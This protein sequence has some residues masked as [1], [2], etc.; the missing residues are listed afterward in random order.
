MSR[1]LVRRL[2]QAIPTLW[3]VSMVMFGIIH[4]APGG[5]MAMY[6]MSPNVDQA[7][8][9]RIEER[10]GLNDP[11]PVQYV[12]W[13]KG[14][15]VGDWGLSYKFGR[16]VT[17][18]LGDRI[19]PSI[20]LVSASLIIALVFSV[21]LGVFSALYRNRFVQYIANAGAMLGVSVPT[22]WL[23]LV[24]LLY[25]SVRI[26]IIPSGGMMTIGLEGFSLWDRLYH[27]LPPAAVLATMHL[28]GW[29]RYVR[30]SMLEVMDQ[31]YI[32]TARS[33]GLAERVVIYRHALKNALL[34][35]VTLV[36]LQGGRLIGGAMITEVVFA[37]PGMGRLLAESLSGRD[38]PVLMASFMMMSVLVVFGNLLADVCYGVIDP[39]IRLE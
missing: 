5:P 6:A 4:L 16:Q 39:R 29:S 33:K 31:D 25:F 23:G 7:E 28:A 36:G 32:Q 34:P 17:A 18:V 14:M 12:R 30:S 10:L 13:L 20:Q 24:I 11:L 15:L 38:Y 8:L 2:L 22:F 35:L 1:F 9:D 19:W 26:R 27:L 37:W 21:P 3:A